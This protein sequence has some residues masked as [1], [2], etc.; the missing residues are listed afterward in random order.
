[1]DGYT[2]VVDEYATVIGRSLGGQQIDAER[3]ELGS[4]TVTQ[5]TR[6]TIVSGMHGSYGNDQ[7]VF[8]FIPMCYMFYAGIFVFKVH[9]F[10]GIFFWVNQWNPYFELT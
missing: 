4:V 2:Y 7:I 3:G 1:M 9:V 10:F 8:L 6:W 5:T